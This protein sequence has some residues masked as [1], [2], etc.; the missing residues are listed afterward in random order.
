VSGVAFVVE[1]VLV[2]VTILTSIV[3]PASRP[4]SGSEGV[5]KVD[6]IEGV[7]VFVN[8]EEIGKTG[9]DGRLFVPSLSSFL[10]NQ[11]S[12]NVANVPLDF[13]FP[14]SVRVVSPSYR[15][16]A[17]VN[18]EA[19]R[20]HAFVGTLKL[21]LNGQVKPAEFF[22]VTL[23]VDGRPLTFVTGRGGEFY[24]ED[25][26]AGCYAAQMSANG[27]SCRFELAVGEAQGPLTDLGDTVCEPAAQTM[28]R[29][30]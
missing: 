1:R 4:F 14:E 9:A 18:F 26:K 11:I 8:N 5:V 13:T 16:G 23:N 6:E 2:I 20:L 10:D 12:I 24:V 30:R 28:N 25:L 3:A 22:E 29:A 21:R 19:K 15:G 27:T 7:R 17:V